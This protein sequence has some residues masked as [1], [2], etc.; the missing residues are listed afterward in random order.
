MEDKGI[1]LIGLTAAYTMLII[2]FGIMVWCKLETLKQTIVAVIRMSLQLL[3][4]GLYLQVVFKLNN[5]FL[6]MLWLII[7]L[8]VADISIVRSAGF[9]VRRLGAAVFIALC[10]G[11][12]IPLTI[13]ATIV[14]SKPA[15]FDARF[16]IPIGGM[17]LGNCLRADIIGIGSFY[18]SLRKNEK[19]YLLSLSQGANLQEATSS[20][21]K[22]SLKSALSPTIATMATI[23]LVSLPGMMTG[24][25]LGG[26]E[27][28]EAI[29]YQVAIM[30]AIFTG[31][32]ITVVLAIKLTKKT[33]F[34]DYGILDK[35]IF[36]VQ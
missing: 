19:A 11:T 34:N 4:V 20:F 10:I 12:A 26:S 13:F 16:V 35:R 25:I 28:A 23:G 21:L 30:I 36:T 27:P 33:A 18:G 31:T 5:P 6:N 3:F 24:V 9:R 32:A 17:I 8:F 14:M 7:M 15:L 29:K 2:P 1:E 22:E